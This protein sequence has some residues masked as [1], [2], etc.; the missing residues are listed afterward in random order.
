[1]IARIDLAKAA[2]T[3]VYAKD[4]WNLSLIP[5]DPELQERIAALIQSTIRRF[6]AASVVEFGCAFWNYAKLVDWSGITY[7]GYDVVAGV[8]EC[9]QNAY[10]APNIRFHTLVEGTKPRS[11]DLLICKDVLQH[12]PTD[13]VLHYLAMFKEQFSYI[14]I[15]NAIQPEDNLNGDIERGGYRPLRLDLPPFNEDC[16][17]LDEWDSPFVLPYRKRACLL[18]GTRAPG[19]AATA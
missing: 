1:M 17:I 12:L 11:A 5:P 10:S 13:D 7:D 19:A 2:F 14:L 3:E 16:E 9:N 15:V 8:I 18:R 6:N 4:L